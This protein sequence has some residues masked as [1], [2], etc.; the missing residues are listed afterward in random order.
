MSN[1]IF[2]LLDKCVSKPLGDGDFGVF[3]GNQFLWSH[4][5]PMNPSLIPNY[6]IVLKED[7][8]G[9]YIIIGRVPVIYN[10]SDYDPI[11][12]HKVWY[13]KQ[14]AIDWINEQVK[15]SN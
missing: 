13:D 10:L 3:L 14:E 11:S 7:A 12:L 2:D 8:P 15:S 9:M 5:Y 4:P 1:V 6:Q